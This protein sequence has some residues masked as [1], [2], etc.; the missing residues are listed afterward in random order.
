MTNV[1][2]PFEKHRPVQV[3]LGDG[4]WCDGYL[5]LYREIEG[6]WSGLVRYTMEPGVTYLGWFEAPPI[7][8]R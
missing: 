2:L 4:V 3:R 1:D 8:G 7:R 6:V 5:E